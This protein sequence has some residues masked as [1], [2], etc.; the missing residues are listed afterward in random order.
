MSLLKCPKCGEM[1]SDTYTDC[2]F[3]EED[4]EL[5]GDGRVKKSGRRVGGGKKKLSVGVPAIV[6]GLVLVVGLV[7]YTMFG[8]QIAALFA[9]NDTPDRPQTETVE[10]NQTD[11]NLTVGKTTVL[12][13]TGSDKITFSSSDETV[14]TVDVNGTVKAV[15]PGTAVITAKASEQSA[16][17]QVTVTEVEENTPT[18]LPTEE[19]L[20][21]QSIYGTSGDISI[22]VG[23][24]APME[25]DGAKEAITWEI[26]NSGIATVD[27]NG[28]V[29]GVATGNTV[30]KATVHGKTLT[31]TIRVG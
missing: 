11:V 16:T 23:E 13:A 10:L 5:Y 12:S 24:S 9:G 27:A 26:E 20:T 4:E 29:T 7:A 3:C 28:T 2:P 6:I 19:T 30:L 21:L 1:F 22:S 8:S 18:P 31:C 17:C 14:A 25:V 15:A